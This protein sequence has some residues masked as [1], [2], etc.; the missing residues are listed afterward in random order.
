VTNARANQDFIEPDF[1]G[2]GEAPWQGFEL[3]K[4]NQ[5]FVDLTYEKGIIFTGLN[6]EFPK[7]KAMR[8]YSDGVQKAVEFNAQLISNDN[9]TIFLTWNNGPPINEESANKVW[10]GAVDQINLKAVVSQVYHGATTLGIN[11]DSMNCK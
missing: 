1:R 2:L 10:L 8:D 3:T 9:K 5:S 6:G 11:A 7:V 4:D